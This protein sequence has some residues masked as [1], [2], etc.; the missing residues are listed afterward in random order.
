MIQQR[1][2]EWIR[3]PEYLNKDS[4]FELRG[5][6]ARYPYFQTVRLLYL[7]NLF[8]LQDSSFKEELRKSA[9]YIADLS[10]LFYYIEGERLVIKQHPSEKS[11]SGDN[12]S[13][14]RTLDLIDR[15]LSDLSEEPAMELPLPSEVSVDYTSIL[16][17]EPDEVSGEPVMLK[18]QELI[19]SFI[20]K[21]KD[22]SVVTSKSENSSLQ[23]PE[24][25]SEDKEKDAGL[26]KVK[27]PEPDSLE[28]HPVEA[29]LSTGETAEPD[30]LEVVKPESVSS[31]SQ[32]EP[33]KV[34]D[35]LD[36]S[37]FTETLAK[38]YVKQ[39]RYDKALEIIKKLNLKYPKKNTYFADQIRFLEKLIINAKSK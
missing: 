31:V 13:S 15:F 4:L 2:Y 21:S 17:Q 26:V 32:E 1:L 24:I 37:Y 33:E 36:E 3:H 10:V 12:S 18:G 25:C 5:L 9:L 39:Q 38:I 11:V 20:E 28:N 35:D 23:E 22:V 6:L 8:L 19:D 14:D 30:L 16:L 34:D 27:L 29:E 7:K